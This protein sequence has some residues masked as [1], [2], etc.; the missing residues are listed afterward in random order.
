MSVSGNSKRAPAGLD[1][2]LTLLDAIKNV[3]KYQEMLKPL[4]EAAANADEA[5]KR[6]GL[7]GD[8][9]KMHAA[10]KRDAD[11]AA[12]SRSQ[13]EADA[14]A[15]LAELDREYS[16]KSA[17]L[18]ER[19]QALDAG[20]GTRKGQ[21]DAREADLNTLGSR[22][23]DQQRELNAAQQELEAAQAQLKQDQDNVAKRYAA[24]KEAFNG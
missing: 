7:A 8:I 14:K 16:Q 18:R 23:A 12:A 24:L 1:Q 5:Y 2:A 15:K 19:Q 11:A 9:E 6:L 20:Y 3:D 10:A 22:L 4:Q 13:A 21:L 17:S